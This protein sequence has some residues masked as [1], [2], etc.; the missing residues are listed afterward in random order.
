MS[1][2][3]TNLT[4]LTQFGR[5][6]QVQV[7]FPPD[8]GGNREV[9]T[10]TDSAFEPEALRVTFDVYTVAW[11]AFWYA[12][13]AIYNL[14]Q[15]TTNKI[16]GSGAP[17]ASQAPPIKQGMEV[18]VS[19]GYQNG[20][21]GVIWDGFVLQPFWE[22]VDVTDFKITLHCVVGLDLISQ[23]SINKTYAAFTQQEEIVRGI[24]NA[25]F[26]KIPVD[27][28]SK[29]L[30]QTQLPRG[31]TVFGSPAK[32]F[33][34]AAEANDMQWWLSS[35]GLNMGKPDEDLAE[36]SRDNII[37]Y[38]PDTGIVGTPQQTQYGVSFRV[39]MDPRIVVKKPLM[40]V[41]IDN[42][43]I[44]LQK[45]QINVLPG[46][47]DQDG[48][49]VVAAARYLGDT[50]GQEWYTE[51]TGYTA[52]GGKLAMLQAAMAASLNG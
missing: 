37:V 9:I 11:Q 28:I 46:I 40:Q 10:I 51:V 34:Q 2:S 43:T 45:W 1:S 29:N 42:S 41:K 33:T 23:N 3:A 32:Y 22:R 14:D 25:A 6:Y 31:K 48:I 15:Q 38:T 52:V 8:E 21:F 18:I 44:R 13:I 27:T 5:K 24:A 16:L 17:V 4:Q 19:A 36:V 26:R 39:L 12:D 20:N 7:L 35:R 50:R 47:L 49:Y 30:P